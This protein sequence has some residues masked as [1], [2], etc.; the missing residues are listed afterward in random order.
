M[1]TGEAV[2]K[3]VFR[4]HDLVDPGEELRFVLPHPEQFRR[5]KAGEGDVRGIADQ[6]GLADGLIQV[7]GLDAGPPVVPEDRG[8]EKLIVLIESDQAVHLS[9]EA[10][11]SDLGRIDPFKQF[12]KARGCLIIPVLRIL[13][14]PAGLRKVKGIRPG[15]DARYFPGT[16]HHKEFDG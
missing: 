11:R 14:R 6:R 1:D 12:V 3:V 4:E 7:F 10:D 15:N 2:Q 9:G 13:F 16:V 5:S 8:T